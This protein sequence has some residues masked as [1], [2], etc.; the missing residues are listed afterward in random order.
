MSPRIPEA[1][2][3][4]VKVVNE[5]LMVA[6]KVGCRIDDLH[7]VFRCLQNISTPDLLTSFNEIYQVSKSTGLKT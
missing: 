4:Y 5:S 6:E 1:P 3:N 7:E 2:N